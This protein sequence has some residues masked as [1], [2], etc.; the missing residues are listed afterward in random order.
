MVASLVPLKLAAFGEK[1][2]GQLS[3]HDGGRYV[4]R[5]PLRVSLWRRALGQTPSLAVAVHCDST[6]DEEAPATGTTITIRPIDC[7]GL[8]A[9]ELLDEMGPP[10]LVSVRTHLD[11]DPERRTQMR[12]PFEQTVQVAP[13]FDGELGDAIV[14]QARDISQRGMS[15]M[16]PCRPPSAQLFV[17]VSLPLRRDTASIMGRVVRVR[18]WKDGRFEVGLAFT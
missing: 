8:Q 15:L 14:S 2:K 3:V 5:L 12:L 17:M 6:S 4:Y 16:M 13:V 11:A 18:S 9:T 1:W 7:S 10:L